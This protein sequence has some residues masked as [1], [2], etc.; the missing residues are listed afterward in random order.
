MI[1]DELTELKE[2]ET[3]VADQLEVEPDVDAVSL[4]ESEEQPEELEEEDPE[5]DVER[6]AAIADY[7]AKLVVLDEQ[8]EE[9]KENELKQMKRDAMALSNYTDEQVQRYLS[10]IDGNTPEEIQEAIS[11]LKDEIPAGG[12]QGADPSPMNGAKKMPKAN[13]FER[14]RQLGKDTAKKLLKGGKVRL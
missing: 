10:H 1:T 12:Y 5:E 6:E 7:T 14:G 2:E 8:I 13:V 3:L 11:R 9:L 4:G